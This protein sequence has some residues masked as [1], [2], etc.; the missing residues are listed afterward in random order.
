MY[1][2]FQEKSSAYKGES[3]GQTAVAFESTSSYRDYSLFPFS[4]EEMF[5]ITERLIYMVTAIE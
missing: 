2:N 3:L 5:L 4:C 1:D